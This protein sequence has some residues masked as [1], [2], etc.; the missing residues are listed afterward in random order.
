MARLLMFLATGCGVGY[1]PWAPGTWGSLMALPLHFVLSRLDARFYWTALAAIVALAIVAAG[2]AEKILDRKDPGV[3]VI[4]E[5]AGM[6]V[7]MVGAPQ[8]LLAYGMGFLLFRLFDILKPFPVRWA[9]Q[10][11]NGGVGIVTDD[12]LAG[13]YALL[14][15]QLLVRL[16]S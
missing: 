16:L 1:L 14:C 6:L 15:L 11:L 4:D 5:V 2:A 10:H 3:V 7:T 13:G 8:T 12:L 9:D